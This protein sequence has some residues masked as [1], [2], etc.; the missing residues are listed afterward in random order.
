[1]AKTAI[2][3][4]EDIVEATYGSPDR[5][6]I[7]GDIEIPCYVL[8]DE[9]RVISQG[10]V[11]NGLGMSKGR[12]AVSVAGDRLVKFSSTKSIRGYVSLDLANALREPI[13]FRIPTGQTA[14]GYEATILTDIC[15]AVL[16]ARDHGD[17]HPQQ[18]HI[19]DQCEVLVR[20]FARIGI[21]ALVDEAD[22]DFQNDTFMNG[23]VTYRT[24]K[25]RTLALQSATHTYDDPGTYQT[26][27][28]VVD[29][30]GNDTSQ[31]FEVTVG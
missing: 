7:I 28:K 26:M 8:A 22:W 12:A 20:A 1:M 6:L 14:Y 2:E 27:V 21:I 25:D 30:F 23:W 16:S 4:A 24:R 11:I 5:P 10:G 3:P 19:A 17:L 15:E 9:K 31:V 13:L 29:I 18:R